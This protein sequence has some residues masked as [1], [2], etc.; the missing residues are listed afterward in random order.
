MVQKLKKR[1][2]TARDRPGTKT[3]IIRVTLNVNVNPEED[4][5]GLPARRVIYTQHQVSIL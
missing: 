1:V 2:C 4:G 3:E 5:G